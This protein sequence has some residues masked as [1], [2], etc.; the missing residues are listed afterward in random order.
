MN[1]TLNTRNPEGVW[2]PFLGAEVTPAKQRN[3]GRIPATIKALLGASNTGKTLPEDCLSSGAFPSRN[4]VVM[5]LID[6]LGYERFKDAIEQTS[7]CERTDSRLSK[8]TAQFPSTT[9]AHITTLTTGLPVGESGIYEW[10]QRDSVSNTLCFPLLFK[11]WNENPNQHWDSLNELIAPKDFFTGTTLMGSL[12][13]EGVDCYC[14]ANKKVN[15]VANEYFE[16]RGTRRF[17]DTHDELGNLLL[18]DM[19]T[20]DRGYFYVYF[21]EVDR[22]GHK[23]GPNSQ[24]Y[25]DEAI[26]ILKAVTR[27]AE[28]INERQ[29]DASVIITA[30]HGHIQVDPHRNGVMLSDIAELVPLF[31]YDRNGE[32]MLPAGAYRDTFLHVK[33]QHV[34]TAVDLVNS[35]CRD[36]LIAYPTKDLID[37]GIFGVVGERFLANV[38]SVA[39]LPI[40]A[41]TIHWDKIMPHQINHKGAHGGMSRE[42]MEIPFVFVN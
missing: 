32:P 31:E 36:K 42:E 9:A 34:G 8:L 18:D 10:L 20:C 39:V 26:D 3:F 1:C 38:G 7:F 33:Q 11:I 2:E 23:H 28:R 15:S 16:S 25:L 37:M 12:E 6:G 22:C 24:E 19:A 27:L 30:D 35:S 5:F 41:R 14:Y 4:K 21:P 13:R 40:G 17:F 29:P